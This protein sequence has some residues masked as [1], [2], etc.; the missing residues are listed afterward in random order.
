[1][2]F[3]LLGLDRMLICRRLCQGKEMMTEGRVCAQ[4]RNRL[5]WVDKIISHSAVFHL[6]ITFP[7][8]YLS[9]SFLL[10]L[11]PSSL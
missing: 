5:W 3:M 1:M 10:S 11:S 2:V 8:K 4:N 6:C 9:P 7:L